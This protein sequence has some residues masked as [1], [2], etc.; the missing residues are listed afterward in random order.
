MI[1]ST[2]QAVWLIVER[3]NDLRMHEFCVLLLRILSPEGKKKTTYTQ[4]MSKYLSLFQ[5]SSH[6]PFLSFFIFFC[7][8]SKR[9]QA[10]W[11]KKTIFCAFQVTGSSVF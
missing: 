7:F 6:V 10:S 9:R 1:G 2:A 8:W 11:Q 5:S 3:H 4:I